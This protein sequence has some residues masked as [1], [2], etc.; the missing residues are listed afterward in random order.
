[1]SGFSETKPLFTHST[2]RFDS[3]RINTHVLVS[4]KDLENVDQPPPGGHETDSAWSRRSKSSPSADVCD[5]RGQP[6]LAVG[7]EGTV[8]RQ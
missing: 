4:E 8:R 2:R 7:L 6:E 5:I 1:M 3:Y